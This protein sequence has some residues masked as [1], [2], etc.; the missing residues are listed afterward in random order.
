MSLPRLVL[1]TAAGCPRGVPTSLSEG[2][3]LRLA[4]VVSCSCICASRCLRAGAGCVQYGAV[5]I[6]DSEEEFYEEEIAKLHSDVE[7]HGLGLIVFAEWYNVDTMVK[8]RFFDDNTRSW[9]TPITGGP[10]HPALC[11]NRQGG[12]ACTGTLVSPHPGPNTAGVLCQRVQESG[13]AASMCMRRR[14]C[15]GICVE[16]CL[17]GFCAG[18]RRCSALNAGGGNI[19]AVNDLLSVFGIGFGDA[20][21]EG[22]LAVGEEK[23][24]YASGVNIA[25]FPAGG[26]LHA[27]QLADKAVVGELRTPQPQSVTLRS[28]LNVSSTRHS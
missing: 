19:P 16:H 1:R 26:T 2:L 9:W 28:H 7:Q 25:R 3:K 27:A 18:H 21:L 17:G 23:I 4:R 24:Y 11:K 6:V 20:L 8:M 22:Q 14:A 13:A 10:S 15:A 12:T 5:L